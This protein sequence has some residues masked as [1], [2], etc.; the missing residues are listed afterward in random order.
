MQYHRRFVAIA[1][2]G[3]LVLGSVVAGCGKK[4]V[5]SAAAPPG[6]LKNQAP[7]VPSG[8]VKGTPEQEAAKAKAIQ[9]GPAVGAAIETQRAGQPAPK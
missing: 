9:Q 6:S 8:E 2:A 3:F 5:D 4:E 1:G 7:T